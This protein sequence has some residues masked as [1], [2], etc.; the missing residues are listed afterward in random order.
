MTETSLID[1]AAQIA[2]ALEGFK[3]LGVRIATDDF[4]GGTSSLTFL[5]ALP[6]DVIKID[7]QFIDGLV[8]RPEDRAIVAAVLSLAEEL[9]LSVIAEGSR[10]SASTPSCAS[11]VAAT[12]R[13]SSM[14]GPSPRPSCGSTA[15]PRRSSRGSATRP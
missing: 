6:I 7:R 14:P 12:G 9:E 5:S 15:T 8:H 10:P 1:D 11:L 4:G 3:E 13:A 2:P